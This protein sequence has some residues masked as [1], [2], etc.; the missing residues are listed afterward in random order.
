MLTASSCATPRATHDA[1]RQAASRARV[2][3]AVARAASTPSSSTPKP[4]CFVFGLGYVGTALAATLTRE[5]AYEVCGTVRDGDKARRLRAHGIRALVWDPF[6]G[7]EDESGP[8][9]PGAEDDKARIEDDADVRRMIAN[10]LARAS[11]VISTV[12]PNGDLDRDPV[13]EV[14]GDVLRDAS[15]T[16]SGGRF[17]GYCSS[18]SV[19][20]DRG[21]DW[22]N[23]NTPCAPNTPKSR[24][25]YDAERAWHALAGDGVTTVSYRLGGI[26]GPGRSAIET[27]KKRRSAAAA[28]GGE[29]S[30]S[31][32]ARERR[33]FTSRVHVGDIVRVIMASMKL[34]EKASE[35]YNVV[36]DEP[37]PRRDA[38][39][40][41]ENILGL[42]TDDSTTTTT[43]T[44]K[45]NNTVRGQQARDSVNVEGNRGEKRVENTRIKTELGVELQFPTYREGLDALARGDQYPFETSSS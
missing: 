2:Y 42:L 15:G 37:A 38:V 41:A 21:G 11:V 10:E 8:P 18:T 31:Q 19:Y 39:R 28:N 12:P 17:T 44:T 45:T 32:R 1:R 20:G 27:A 7:E 4:L 3:A 29:E 16:P 6:R 30:A 24:A 9:S 14:F 23:E 34:G 13:L 22:V 43:M 36:D 25:R 33:S 40:Y 35:V 26:Y 5:G